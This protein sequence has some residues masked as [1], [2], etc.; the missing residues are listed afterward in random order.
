MHNKIPKD[1]SEIRTEQYQELSK[2]SVSEFNSISIYN[3]EILSIITDTDKDDDE[4]LDMDTDELYTIYKNTV[5]LK[6]EPSKKYLNALDQYR[7][8]DLNDLTLGEFIDIEHF[9][10]NMIDNLHIICSILYKQTKLNQWNI[11]EYEPYEYNIYE[12]SNMFLEIEITK[13]YG[14]INLYKEWKTNFIDNYA[15]LFE[16]D[17]DISEEE[18]FDGLDEDE[19]E[20]LKR[21]GYNVEYLD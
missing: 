3:L 10:N 8:K 2:I 18:M 15:N 19:I 9:C 7:L 13:I 4:W 16:S 11:L 14:I 5:W 17:S 1:W 12:R 6:S 21:Q 20:E